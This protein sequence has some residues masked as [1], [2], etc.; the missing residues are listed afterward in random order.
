MNISDINWKSISNILIWICFITTSI[1]ISIPEFYKYGI[2]SY[3]LELWRIDIFILQMF[4]WTFMHWWLLHLLANSIFIF[5][6]WNIVEKIIWLKNYIVFFITTVIITWISLITLTSWT[7]VWIS[8][9]AMALLWFFTITLYK[10]NNPDYKWGI[11]A[12][13]INIAIWLSPWI[14]LIWHLSWAIIWIIY[15]LIYRNKKY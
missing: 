3:F 15:W 6:F 12:I 11:T 2:N 13:I 9:F 8:W 5:L 1:V 14:S 7:T 10:Q 4:S